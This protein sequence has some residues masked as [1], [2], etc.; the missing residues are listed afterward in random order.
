MSENSDAIV[1][2]VSEETG[3][4]SVAVEG[5]LTPVSYTDTL[6]RL[7]TH[8][9]AANG[10]AGKRKFRLKRTGKVSEKKRRTKDDLTKAHDTVK[11]EDM[12]D[13]K[14]VLKEEHEKQVETA[15]PFAQDEQTMTQEKGE[16]HGE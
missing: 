5:R 9:L 7:L 3:V 4:I 11:P 14:T 10:V 15:Q 13:E 12:A 1:V 6:S 8:Y 16:R 2:I